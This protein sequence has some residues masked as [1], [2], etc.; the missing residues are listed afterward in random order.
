[1][2][3]TPFIY[4]DVQDGSRSGTQYADLARHLSSTTEDWRNLERRSPSR[5][6]RLGIVPV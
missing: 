6:G 5:R 2:I 3:Q 1:M 4:T